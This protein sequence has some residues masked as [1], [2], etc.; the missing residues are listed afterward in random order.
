MKIFIDNGHWVDTPG[1]RILDWKLCEHAWNRLNAPWIVAALTG[2]G[3]DAQLLMQD[4]ENISLSECGRRIKGIAGYTKSDAPLSVSTKPPSTCSASAS[5]RWYTDQC[6]ASRRRRWLRY[7]QS[8]GRAPRELIHIFSVHQL[9]Q[10]I[11]VACCTVEQ[12]SRC[13]LQRVLATVGW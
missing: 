3:H 8:L 6:G 10:V 7:H 12:T 11:G 5:A 1:K 13:C 9:V 2:L 4:Q